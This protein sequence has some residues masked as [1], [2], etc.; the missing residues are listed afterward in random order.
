LFRV[1]DEKEQT[2]I[3]AKYLN[4]LIDDY[5]QNGVDLANTKPWEDFFSLAPQLKHPKFVE[6]Q[7][8]RLIS[9][10][11]LIE[12]AEFRVGKSML[13][14]YVRLRLFEFQGESKGKKE[15]KEPL[16][17]IPEIYIGPTPHLELSNIFLENLLRKE[18]VFQGVDF[19]Q[20]R[21]MK[22]QIKKSKIPYR[23]W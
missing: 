12:K 5:R 11:I 23:L 22:C 21:I 19:D 15:T 8:W 10:P 16:S 3:V 7:E 4:T 13:V 2:E 6:E 1:Y 20:G 18:K 17:C 14:P 9:K